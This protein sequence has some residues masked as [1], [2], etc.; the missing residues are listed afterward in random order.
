MNKYTLLFFA[1]MFPLTFL[2]AQDTLVKRSGERILV[3]VLEINS[4]DIRYKRYN[5]P[6]GPLYSV[7]KTEVSYIVF[8]TGLKEKYDS[9]PISQPVVS[10]PPPAV[11]KENVTRE[12]KTIM[13]DGHFYLYRNRRLAE[14]DVY[15]L[16]AKQ[17]NPKLMLL[18][19]QTKD[20]RTTQ[21]LLGGGGLLLG[22]AGGFTALGSAL[23]DSGNNNQVLQQNQK[24][25]ILAIFELGLACEASSLCCKIERKK[26]MHSLLDAYNGE[27]QP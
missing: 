19:K 12:D 8:S 21:Y 1:F 4:S 5:N 27:V 13:P 16:I 7:Y 24:T 17:K 25:A 20:C 2:R 6:D 11:V 10:T 26:R 9:E 18:V 22:I 14:N 15:D 3:K 23:I